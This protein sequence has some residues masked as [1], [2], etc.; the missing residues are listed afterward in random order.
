MTTQNEETV[1]QAEDQVQTGTTAEET[2][3]TE[4]TQEEVD[5]SVR[6]PELEAALS[7]SDQRLKMLEGVDRSQSTRDERI[8]RIEDSIAGLSQSSAKFMDVMARDDEVL[9]GELSTI[10]SET[11][12]AQAS[13]TF[14][15]R[16]E[17]LREGL[18][19]IVQGEGEDLLISEEDSTKLLTQWNTATK[20][21]ETTGDTAPL[22]EVHIAAE[23]MVREAARKSHESALRKEKTDSKAREKK[24]LE[25]AGVHDHDTGP[26]TSGGG[27]SR[28]TRE[29]M[30]SALES[31]NSRIKM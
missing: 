2:S 5:W 16:A 4:E 8:A 6:G 3:T 22:Y 23:R 21:A 25:N 29:K 13:R 11:Q 30:A 17:Q 31:G 26:I 14:E 15:T 9:K 19:G 20:K 12:V 1:T 10:K 7:K 24:A 27:D 28:S 18:L